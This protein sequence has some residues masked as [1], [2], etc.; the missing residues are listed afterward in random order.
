[1]IPAP[2]TAAWLAVAML[3]AG[4]SPRDDAEPAHDGHHRHG[5][6]APAPSAPRDAKHAELLEIA[7]GLE[8]S[9]DPYYGRTRLEELLAMDPAALNPAD[10]AAYALALAFEEFKWGDP[11]KAESLALASWRASGDPTAEYW[12][13]V[14]A[15]RG[16]ELDNCLALHNPESC[17]LPLEGEGVHSDPAGA[18]RAIP[19]LTE[20]ADG[21]PPASRAIARLLLNLSHMAVGDWPDAVPEGLRIGPETFSSPG[22]VG[23]F[24]DRASEAGMNLM[25]HAGGAAMDDF[26]GDG[27]LDVVTTTSWPTGSMR[28]WHNRGDG[29]FE[30]RTEAAGLAG[31]VGGLNLVHADYDGDGHLDLLVLRGAWLLERGCQPRSLLRNEGDGRF[32]DVTVAAGLDAA[33]YPTQNAAFADYDLDGDLDLFIGSEAYIRAELSY[34]PIGF[35]VAGGEDLRYPSQLYRNEGDGTFTDVAAAAGVENFGYAKGAAWGDYDDDGFPDLYVSNQWGPNRLY[36]NVGDGRFTDV[37]GAMGVAEPLYSFPAWFWDYDNDGRLDLFVASYR[38][39]PS[40]SV[41]S[42]LRGDHRGEDALFRN[43]PGGFRNL[44]RE[45]GLTR[46]TLTMGANF[47]DADGDGW[48]DLYM[49]TGTPRFDA[50]VP[51]VLYRADG[52]GGFTD[53]TFAAGLGNVQKGHGVAFGDVD[54]DGDE[55]LLLQSGGFFPYDSYFNSLYENPGHG[56]RWITVALEGTK[57]NRSGIGARI[58]VTVEEGGRPRD[59]YRW[60]GAAGSFGSSSLQQ[61]IGLGRAERIIALEVRW[62]GNE[63]TQRFEDLEMDRFYR[64]TEGAD[65][66]AAVERT[67]IRL[68]Q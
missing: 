15:L 44:A 24:R 63:T 61:E 14:A 52:R 12:A 67:R 64:V 49:G 19:L 23:R 50:L 53:E 4:C 68:A 58:R 33:R 55:D 9:E 47:A 8:R 65:S 56:N 32:A 34:E 40:A 48:L 18:R 62:P 45:A 28:Y 42:Y 7:H 59:V 22:A 36:R 11:A 39:T 13:G 60:V 46:L 2:R 25:E 38:G 54:N 26:D 37:A 57:S 66:P 10:A 27:L 6:P 21:V 51:N 41:R 17:L 35:D 30:D 29:T 43:E 3:A 1:M 31:Q 5:S 20:S 16:G